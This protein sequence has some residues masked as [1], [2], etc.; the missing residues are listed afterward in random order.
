MCYEHITHVVVDAEFVMSE[1]WLWCAKD[2][3]VQKENRLPFKFPNN[4]TSIYLYLCI[5][6]VGTWTQ[7]DDCGRGEIFLL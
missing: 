7:I 6:I 1:L 4:G 2:E 3:C 5:R